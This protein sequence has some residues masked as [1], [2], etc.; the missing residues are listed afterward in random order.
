M[1]PTTRQ[2]PATRVA[3]AG[4]AR[5]RRRAAARAAAARGPRRR[6]A[7]TNSSA[8]CARI[9]SGVSY[10]AS[11]PPSRRIAIRSPIVI[12]SSMSCVTKIDR[13]RDLAVQAPQLLLEPRA[14]DRVERA[15][16]L[17]HQQHRR[18]G[19]ERAREADALALPARELAP[20]SAARPPARAR[21][22]RAARPTRS[23]DPRLRPAEQARH[24]GD[25]VGDRHVREEPDL[26]DHVADPAP[27]L[28]DG[29]VADAAP[30]DRDVALVEGDQPVDQLQRRRLAAARTG[31]R[32]RR[33]SRPGSRA[34]ARASAA[35]SRPA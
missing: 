13:L 30:V 12:A 33:T 18:I 11:T 20:G 5:R 9:A 34:R 23:R 7:S 6:T 2:R 29:Q 28:D 32:A 27:Q 10:W 17:V 14:R 24:G 16:R 22:A 31:R 21:R 26:L 15:E 25:V 4:R 1:R 19:G 8:G 35:P 3:D